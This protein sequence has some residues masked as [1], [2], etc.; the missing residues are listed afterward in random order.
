[1]DSYYVCRQSLLELFPELYF[2]LRSVPSLLDWNIIINSP[3]SV[4]IPHSK[5]GEGGIEKLAV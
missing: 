2:V 1:M 3:S 5:A 4:I